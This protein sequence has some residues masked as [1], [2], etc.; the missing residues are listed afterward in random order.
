[1]DPSEPL[2]WPL[3]KES[4]RGTKEGTGF[5][6]LYVYDGDVATEGKAIGPAV[7]EGV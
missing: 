5:W 3:E 4:E 2:D 1:M 6:T 7:I